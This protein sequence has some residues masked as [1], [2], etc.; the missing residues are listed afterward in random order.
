MTGIQLRTKIN[1]KE[2]DTVQMSIYLPYD[3]IEKYEKQIPMQVSG[4]VIW[5]KQEKSGY[6]R[7]IKFEALNQDQQSRLQECFN[8]FKNNLAIKAGN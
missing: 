2:K 8:Y 4:L 7:G 6:C 1:L 5:Q 3:D